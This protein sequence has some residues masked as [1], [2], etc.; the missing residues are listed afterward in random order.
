[1]LFGP[2]GELEEN[3]NSGKWTTWVIS[4]LTDERK[5]KCM[6]GFLSFERIL[7]LSTGDSPSSSVH[8]IKF[9]PWIE[10]HWRP[11]CRQDFGLYQIVDCFSGTT[12]EEERK[13]LFLSLTRQQSHNT[14]C[15]SG[16]HINGVV[17]FSSPSQGNEY[18][19]ESQRMIVRLRFPRSPLVHLLIVLEKHY[20]ENRSTQLLLLFSLLLCSLF[21]YQ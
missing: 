19:M 8:D 18:N 21:C 10:V 7:F 11:S 6:L 5:S 16:I 1:M 2:L 3:N 15:N 4:S 13:I 20:S 17:Q 14:L 12:V 9:S